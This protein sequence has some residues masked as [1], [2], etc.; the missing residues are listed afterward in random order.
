MLHPTFRG[1]RYLTRGIIATIEPIVQFA[2]WDYL[3]AFVEAHPNEVDYLQIFRLKTEFREGKL[4]LV[5]NHEQEVPKVI[6][7]EALLFPATD[8]INEKVYVISDWDEKGNEYATM[9][10]ASEY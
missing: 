9:L 3:D 10:L 8:M 7:N 5:V 4:T 1:K 6:Q 2:I